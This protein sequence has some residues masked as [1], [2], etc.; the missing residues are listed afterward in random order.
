MEF[1]PRC[2]EW[3]HLWKKMEN[4]S[5]QIQELE[6]ETMAI[7]TTRVLDNYDSLL[8][9]ADALAE[10]DVVMSFADLAQEKRW[11]KPV[12]DSR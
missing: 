10:L 4:V 3:V 11:T 8:Q 9:T 2:K 5:L 6:K 1:C 7:L 12:V